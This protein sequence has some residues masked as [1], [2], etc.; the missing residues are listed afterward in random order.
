MM[1]GSGQ[2][3]GEG[4][5]FVEADKQDAE[6]LAHIQAQAFGSD[7]ERFGSGP[8]GYD[9]VE[10]QIASM[11][12]HH[13]YKILAGEQIIG[14]IIVHNEGNEEYYLHRLFIDP[15]FQQRGVASQALTFLEANFPAR[16]WTLHTPN[17]NLRNQHFY[18][19]RGYKKIG[20]LR[21]EGVP[22]R[23]DF[24]LYYYEKVMP[25]LETPEPEPA[26]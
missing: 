17:L 26:L 4:V 16:R 7:A 13:Y 22:L 19:K 25:R 5:R 18:E 2:G 21:P 8:P 23:E 12:R 14:G 24:V 10:W 6:R 9:D 11:E 15:A 3:S 1:G 20:E